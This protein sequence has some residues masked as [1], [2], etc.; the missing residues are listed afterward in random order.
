LHIGVF[1]GLVLLILF[2]TDRLVEIENSEENEAED[3][4]IFNLLFNLFKPPD[5]TTSSPMPSSASKF[6]E[7]I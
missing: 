4:I 6:L 1:F 5:S 2:S 7:K 3:V